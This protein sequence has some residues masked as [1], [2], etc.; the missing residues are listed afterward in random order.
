M[1]GGYPVPIQHT[2]ARA[3]GADT[4]VSG[5]VN[6]TSGSPAN[7]KGSWTTI[8]AST[9]ADLTHLLIT[10]SSQPGAGIPIIF[11]IAAA[12]AASEASGLICQNIIYEPSFGI[13]YTFM[14][15][16]GM[17]AAGSRIA[18]RFASGT[19]SDNTEVAMNGF[20]SGW[21]SEGSSAPIDTYGWTSGVIQGLSVDPGATL[22]TKGAYTQITSSATNDYCGFF[23]VFD[24]RLRTGG[25]NA[26]G[27]CLIDIALGASGSEVVV[28]P[29]FF[30]VRNLISGQR[31]QTSPVITPI[32][33]IPIATGSR[34]AIRAQSASNVA[35]DRV[36]GVSFHG[37]RR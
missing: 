37:D 5:G 33:R 4:T 19:A 11:D 9:A 15:P 25:T 7:T 12:P 3:I 32:F 18:F 14:I 21:L 8:I 10:L 36:F 35:S 29:N 1:A 20:D 22:N 16:C 13:A 2:N 24:N 26:N 6:V 27:A 34:I 30:L 17:V 31:A 28:L 23:L